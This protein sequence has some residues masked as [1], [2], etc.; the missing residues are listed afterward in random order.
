MKKPHLHTTGFKSERGMG[1]TKGVRV[2]L[3]RCSKLTEHSQPVRE[4][5]DGPGVLHSLEGMKTFFDFGYVNQQVI[6]A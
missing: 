5:Q 1:E 6:K 3:N 4:S 2:F